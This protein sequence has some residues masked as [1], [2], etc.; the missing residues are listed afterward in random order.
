M[1]QSTQTDEV[2][3]IA[4]NPEYFPVIEFSVSRFQ[5]LG[6]VTIMM[7]CMDEGEGIGTQTNYNTLFD[8]DVDNYVEELKRFD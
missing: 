4:D 7:Y 2:F 3:E 8:E 5:V 6:G 1:E